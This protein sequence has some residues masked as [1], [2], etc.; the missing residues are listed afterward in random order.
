MSN[1]TVLQVPISK[2]LKDAAE[3]VALD[4]GFSSLQETIK[5]ILKKLSTRELKVAMTAEEEGEYV[6]L[7]P[8]AV[9]RYKRMIRDFKTGKNVY[10]A[11]D[12][13]DFLRQLRS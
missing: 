1:Q 9:R 11:K 7:S 3:A 8:K 5:V 12:V 2:T 10:K 4:Y 13:D 6:T